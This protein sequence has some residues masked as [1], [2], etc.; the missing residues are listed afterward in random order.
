[1]CGRQIIDLTPQRTNLVQLTA[2]QT[3]AFCQNHIA[4]GLTL[5]VVI[6][7]VN[8]KLNLVGKGLL[9][10]VGIDKLLLDCLKTLFTLMLVCNSLLAE[11]VALLVHGIVQ[12]LA[13]FFVVHLVAILAFLGLAGLNSQFGNSTALNLDGLVC[14]L[15]SVQH[16][17]FAHLFHLAF[18][19]HN[20]LFGGGNNQIKVSALYILHGSVNDILSVE[21]RHTH[22][23]HGTIERY[24]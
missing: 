23:G 10:V 22:L 3:A 5:G 12:T 13:Q 6:I 18:H 9:G 24:V 1:M 11:I 8:H 21:I 2:V 7:A 15:Q 4:H 19:H 14:G 17:L 16:H 20:I